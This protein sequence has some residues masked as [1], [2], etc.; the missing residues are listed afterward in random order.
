MKIPQIAAI[1]L[2]ALSGANATACQKHH[3]TNQQ[4]AEKTTEEIKKN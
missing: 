1:V 3:H 2:L 4:S